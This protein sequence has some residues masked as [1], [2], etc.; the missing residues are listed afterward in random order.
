MVTSARSHTNEEAGVNTVSYALVMSR[1]HGCRQIQTVGDDTD[2]FVLLVHFYWKL[3]SFATIAMKQFDG[4][5]IDINATA[6]PL[7]DK[8]VKLL[9]MHAIT[10]CDSVSY[11]FRKGNVSS[12]KVIMDSYDIE[13]EVFGESNA[14]ISD[15]LR[16]GYRMFEN[17]GWNEAETVKNGSHTKIPS[18]RPGN[19]IIILRQL[20][21]MHIT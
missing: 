14:T 1:E 10:V 18:W 20:K 13:I 4:K 11:T 5:T 19:L 8:C 9:P 3:R 15:I 17:I 2:V 21:E 7:G 16:T 12:L 6:M